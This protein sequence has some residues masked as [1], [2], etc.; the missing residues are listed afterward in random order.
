MTDHHPPLP[1]VELSLRDV[2]DV[3]EDASNIKQYNYRSFT[4]INNG[5]FSL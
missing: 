2:Y 4:E 3:L 5:K 1:F